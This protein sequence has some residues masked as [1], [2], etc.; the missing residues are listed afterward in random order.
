ME[1]YLNA[2][3]D[4]AADILK[5]GTAD[6]LSSYEAQKVDLHMAI[7]MKNDQLC[8]FMQITVKLVSTLGSFY[9]NSKCASLF[10]RWL[11][12]MKIV[13][14]IDSAKVLAFFSDC[15]KMS[16]GMADVQQ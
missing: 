12:I 5:G 13:L 7:D 9:Q 15:S 3:E 4:A 2:A 14:M 11:R 1:H 16:I 8:R 10:R 6:K